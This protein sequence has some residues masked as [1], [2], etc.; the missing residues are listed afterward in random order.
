MAM[1][2]LEIEEG[3]RERKKGKKEVLVIK[4]IAQ[5]YKKG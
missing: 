4:V 1:K 5:F 2:V 3:R